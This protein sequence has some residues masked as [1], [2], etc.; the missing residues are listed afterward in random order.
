MAKRTHD[1]KF[2]VVT[3]IANEAETLSEFLNLKKAE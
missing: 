1:L 3:P 2:A